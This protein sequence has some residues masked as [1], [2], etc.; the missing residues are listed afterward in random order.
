MVYTENPEEWTKKLLE[1][2]SNYCKVAGYKVS[3]QKSIAFL[4]TSN[5]QVEFE[6]KNTKSFTLAPHKK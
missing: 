2:I 1:L 3:T 5:E 6:V 4:C